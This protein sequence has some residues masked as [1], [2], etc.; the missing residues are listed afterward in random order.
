MGAQTDCATLVQLLSN[1]QA[2]PTLF[3][4]F[5]SEIMALREIARFHTIAVPITFTA[6]TSVVILPPPVI[7]LLTLIYN[8]TVLSDLGLRELESMNPGWRN[9]VGSPYA[10]TRQ[11]ENSKQVEVYPVPYQTSPPIIPIHGLPT[12][13]DYTPGNGIAVYME[14]RAGDC[15]PYLVLPV[16]LYVLEREY[17][18]ESD[19]MD[20]AFAGM[21]K[22]IGKQLLAL[23]GDIF[24]GPRQDAK[25]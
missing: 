14:I 8:D 1:G 2:D 23:L 4:N 7:N 3:N 13:R 22:E 19:H 6:R 10:F 21:C 16:A 11:A 9:T 12:G 24:T 5:Y 20:L 18:R 25:S 15:L 17:L